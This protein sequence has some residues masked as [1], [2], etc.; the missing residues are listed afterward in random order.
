MRYVLCAALLWLGCGDERPPLQAI[1][2]GGEMVF[3]HDTF[4]DAGFE[5]AVRQAL[6]QPQGVLAEEALVGLEQL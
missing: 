5:K 3:D 1:G 2:E 4:A 6:G